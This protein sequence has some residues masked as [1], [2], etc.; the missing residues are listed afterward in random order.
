MSSASPKKS[1][2]F[3]RL[4][5]SGSESA[6]PDGGEDAA[7]SRD[8]LFYSIN[9]RPVENIQLPFFYKSHTIT[10]LTFTFIPIIYFAFTRD[11]EESLSDNIWAGVKFIIFLSLVISTLAFPNGPFTRPH[12]V[13][14]RM[15]FG[16]SVLYLM[17]LTFILFQNYDT[18][19]SML[20]WVFPDL[21]DF[22]IDGEK[23]YG[24]N[25]SDVSI[26][27]VWSHVDVFALGHFFGWTLKAMLIRHY[28]IAWLI[29]VTWEITEMTFSHLLPNFIE[30]WW[31]ALI[32]DVLICNGAGIWLGMYICR[33]LE[34]RKYQWESIKNISSTKGKIKRAVLQF[35]PESW[36]SMKWLD[37]SCTYIRYLAVTQ[38]VIYWQITELNTF[39]L[40]HIFEIPPG[41]PL[42]IGRLAIIALIVAPS[43]RQYYVYVV[44][45]RC[46][47]VG[48]QCWVFGAIMFI[49]SIICI[50]FGLDLFAQTQIKNIAI[51]IIIQ[52]ILSIVFVSLGVWWTKLNSRSQDHSSRKDR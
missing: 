31:D 24:I 25:C 20:N 30:C 43:L 44:D 12:P 45:A 39:F 18:V 40:K 34:M 49:E 48:S 13:M 52:F 19:K 21:E 5:S 47:R 27:R 3:T 46:K 10:L 14:W 32:L 38:L 17:A 23:E 28:G 41:H 6:D 50:R 37:P 2:L 42:S 33:K 15:V 8:N 1:P 29:S 51:W 4:K 7:D 35:T 11:T 9:E 22:T 16:I 36:T 26:E